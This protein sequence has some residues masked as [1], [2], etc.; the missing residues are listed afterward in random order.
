M[1]GKPMNDFARGRARHS[2]R[3]ALSVNIDEGSLRP[4]DSSMAFPLLGERTRARAVPTNDCLVYR[5]V[6]EHAPDVESATSGQIQII[7]LAAESLTL[8][9]VSEMMYRARRIP[10]RPIDLPPNLW[11][12]LA[13]THRCCSWLGPC[14]PTKLFNLLWRTNLIVNPIFHCDTSSPREMFPHLKPRS[15]ARCVNQL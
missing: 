13:V 8:H 7:L 5:P 9:D 6:N 14:L 3:A 15:L 1:N 2:V 11:R 10:F 12:I 4:E